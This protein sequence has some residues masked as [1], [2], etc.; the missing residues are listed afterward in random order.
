MNSFGIA[1]WLFHR[2]ILFDKTMTQLEMPAACKAL[3]VETI[4]LVSSFFPSQD[5]RYLN[6]LRTAINAQGL[7]VRNIA[8]DMGDIANADEA[9]RRTDIETLKQ[10][11]H[12][13][14]AVGAESIRVNSGAADP[15]DSAAIERIC[16]G[17]RELADEAE[18]T[19]VYLLIEN[20]GGASADPQNIQIFLDKVASPWF[21]TCPDTGNFLEGTWEQGMQIMA[22]HAFSCHVKA[23]NY[24]PDG[25]QSRM[26]RDGQPRTY[27]LRRSLQ[28]LK[29]AGYEGPLCIEAGA[30][31]GESASGRDAIA[32]VRELWTSL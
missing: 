31:E 13:A 5:A 15:D 7:G 17:Y 29:D 10:W 2:S 16:A 14:R 20:H 6:E 3:G 18:H 28:I 25:E 8:V 23:F 19:G 1:G 30:S 24:S 9:T 26:G 12:V 21:K 27:N 32:Y 22:P 4:E 11:F